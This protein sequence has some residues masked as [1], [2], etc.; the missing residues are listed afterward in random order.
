[1]NELKYRF[2][3][4]TILERLSKRRKWGNSHTHYKHA[5]AGLPRDTGGSKEV[6]QAFSDLIKE[7]KIMLKKTVEEAHISLNPKLSGE[8]KAEINASTNIC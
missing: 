8:I 5:L 7:N 3:R 4:Q 6:K 1:M 2:A